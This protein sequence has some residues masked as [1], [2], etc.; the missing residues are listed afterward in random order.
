MPK[1]IT[2]ILVSKVYSSDYL[3]TKSLW[4]YSIATAE[5]SCGYYCCYLQQMLTN[6]FY[7]RQIQSTV[8]MI[9]YF[10]IRASFVGDRTIA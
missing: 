4:R 8:I 10:M 1:F 7:I 3:L 2:R 6:G 5:Y 9:V